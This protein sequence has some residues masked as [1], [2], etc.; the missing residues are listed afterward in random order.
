M[1]RL[2]LVAASL[3]TVLLF[4]PAQARADVIQ[5]FTAGPDCANVAEFAWTHD[6]FFG[7]IFAVNNLSSGAFAGSFSSI[8]VSPTGDPLDGAG[9][10]PDPLDPG[11]SAETFDAISISDVAHLSFLFHDTLFTATLAAADLT[12]DGSGFGSFG[13][14]LLLA[15]IVDTTPVPEP[16]SLLLLGTGLI[17][18]R[19]ARRLSFRSR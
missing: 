12:D 11:L 15:S 19:G 7:D 16:A 2:A 3:L 4:T 5:C 10:L 8:V 14:T 13:S 6:E 17:A 1:R 18:W 9:V